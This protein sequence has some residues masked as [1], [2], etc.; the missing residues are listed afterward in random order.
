MADG[1]DFSDALGKKKKLF[2]NKKNAEIEQPEVD[3]VKKL[4]D[5]VD[6]LLSSIGT[7]VNDAEIERAT[8]RM[9]EIQNNAMTD[10]RVH[11]GRLADGSMSGLS[12]ASIYFCTVMAWAEAMLGMV[13]NKAHEENND[14]IKKMAEII[15]ATYPSTVKKYRNDIFDHLLKADRNQ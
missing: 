1:D 4:I 2:N 14:A 6:S 7:G 3:D 8:Q 15:S 13:L 5:I 10:C 12:E 11:A 9:K